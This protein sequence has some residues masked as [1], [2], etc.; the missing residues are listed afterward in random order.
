MYTIQKL[1][2]SNIC[3]HEDLCVDIS[4]GL[5]AVTGPNGSGKTSLFRG[6]VY[7]LTGLVDGSWGT[8]QSLQKDGTAVPGF[9]EVT[10]GGSSGSYTIRRYSVAASN[11][12]P[13]TII[14]DDGVEVARRR[15]AVDAFVEELIGIPVQLMF[16]VCWGRQ[17]ELASLLKATPATIS[18]FLSKV[19][20]VTRLEIIREKLKVVIDKIAALPG[21]VETTLANDRKALKELPSEDTLQASLQ[22]C[23]QEL[24]SAQEALQLLRQRAGSALSSVDLQ[25]AISSTEQE[26]HK[27]CK[28]AAELDS[29]ADEP[30]SD[31]PAALLYPVAQQASER[32]AE[33]R[34]LLSES[35]A[36][37]SAAQER[38]QSRKMAEERRRLERELVLSAATVTENGQ[39]QFCGSAVADVEAYM[40][41]V[42]AIL[43]PTAQDA[44]PFDEAAELAIIESLKKESEHLAQSVQDAE[45]KANAVDR[46]LRAAQRQEAI[47]DV[48]YL[49]NELRE[50]KATPVRSKEL[51]A[52][53]NAAA[54]KVGEL[55]AS[56]DSLVALIASTKA[57]R[58]MLT[59]AVADDELAVKRFETNTNARTALTE[60]RDAF[61]A[62]RAQARYLKA[63]IAALNSRLAHHM[64]KTGM[65]F[66]LRLDTDKRCFVFVN[67]DG[68]EHPACHLSG[69]Q[70][71][72]SAVALQMA[73]LDVMKPGMNLYLIDEPTEALDENNKEVMASMFATM[74][75][76]LPAVSGTM[77]IVTR[78]EAAIQACTARI[79]IG[80]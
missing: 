8:Q 33:T 20:D 71:G 35:S 63:R 37:L 60:L 34:R 31:A 54:K 3:Q 68:V 30:P 62:P 1:R 12:F 43:T 5:T 74:S 48:D 72:M 56:R 7:A 69:A 45:A 67:S 46:K 16:Q 70:Q 28:R 22:K 61:S 47:H 39:C 14:R 17:G 19:F 59:K 76:M 41:R 52:E 78:D 15:S 75:Q 64:E 27:A 24:L 25:S 21:G 44:Q 65:P 26:L 73:L 42:S 2:L 10:I 13:D 32:V 4:T 53:L 9:A 80:N 51:D 18:A 6:L 38:L 49:S 11:K 23:E 29:V 77:L 40:K 57:R 66:S 79:E 55:L 36:R 58:E 50:L